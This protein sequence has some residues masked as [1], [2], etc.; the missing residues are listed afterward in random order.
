M[1]RAAAHHC[2]AVARRQRRS[3]AATRRSCA[4][5]AGAA[6]TPPPG[7]VGVLTVEE[8]AA[9]LRSP[10]VDAFQL[11]DVREPWE[12]EK[13]SVD[14]FR[15]IPLSSWPAGVDA[16]D[17][18]KPTAVMCLAGGRSLRFATALATTLGFSEVYN[19]RGGIS[20]WSVMD[21]SVPTYGH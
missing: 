13:A 16:L 9:L 10:A 21:P 11:V 17:P 19:I 12:L 5:M 3:V 8:V 2:A 14:G 6:G 7:T 15:S 1:L 18:A 20:A 4:A